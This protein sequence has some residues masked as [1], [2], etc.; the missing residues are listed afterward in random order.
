MPASGSAS[1]PEGLQAG[2]KSLRL[3]EILDKEKEGFSESSSILAC[4]VWP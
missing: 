3:G 1:S 4:L 2:G